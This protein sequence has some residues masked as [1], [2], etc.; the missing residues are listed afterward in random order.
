MNEWIGDFMT[1]S[2]PFKTRKYPYKTLCGN[3]IIRG[4]K[5]KSVIAVENMI[6]REENFSWT[7]TCPI[8]I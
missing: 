5:F 1:A 4:K 7:S 3:V 8:F 6:I 2:I